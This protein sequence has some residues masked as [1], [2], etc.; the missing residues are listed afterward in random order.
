MKQSSLA[1]TAIAPFSS[2]RRASMRGA[3]TFFAAA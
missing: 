1:V 2:A 3:Q